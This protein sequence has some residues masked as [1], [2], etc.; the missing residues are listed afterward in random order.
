MEFRKATLRDREEIENYFNKIPRKS[1]E[2]SFTTLFLWQEQYNMEF[3]F[4]DSF[5]YIRSDIGREMYL[6][7]IGEGDEDMALDKLV[8]RNVTFYSLSEKQV[9]KIEER[10]PGKYSYKESRDMGDYIYR[11]S[12]LAYLKGKKLSAKRNHINRFISENP[13]WRYEKITRD[14]IDD[15]IRMHMEWC[16]LAEDEKGLSEETIAVKK[17]LDNY[18]ELG[19]AGG[20]IRTGGKVVAFSV[21]DKL[22]DDT[23][24]VH[25]EK[26]FSEYGGAYQLI[27]REFVLNNCM[28]YEFINRE[29]DSGNMG[30]RKAKLSYRPCEIVKKYMAKVKQK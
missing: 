4:E 2:Y 29:D 17:A 13:D 7:P 16:Q 8:S 18:F 1:L 5:L 26:A 24:L 22:S 19:F 21:G 20:L 12:D 9:S 6:Y 27:N 11:T 23:F 28:D 10:Y 30:L 15:V 14:N 25:I 3:S